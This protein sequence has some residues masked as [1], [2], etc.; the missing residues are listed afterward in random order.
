MVMKT[1]TLFLFGAV[2]ATAVCALQLPAATAEQNVPVTSVARL[3]VKEVTVFKDGHA[4]VA[5]EGKLPVNAAGEVVMDYL[6]TPVIGTFWAYPA[7]RNAKLVSVTASQRRMSIERTAL[8]LRELLEANVGAEASLTETN[9]LKYPVTI[10]GFPTRSAEE[11]MATSPPNAGERLPQKGSLVLLKTA[12]GT[13]ALPVDRIQDVTF[14]GA[15]AAKSAQE[16]FRN[17]LTLRMD[18]GNRK[19]AKDAEVG[20]GLVYL[21]KGIRWIPSYR[22]DLD[23]KG[24]AHIRLQATLLNELTDLDDVTVQL[25]IGV[26]TFYFKET[27]DPMALQESAAQ[28]SAFFQGEPGRAGRSSVLAANFSNAIMTQAARMGDYRAESGPAGGSGPDLPEGT[29]NEDLFVFTLKNISL[30]KG[31]RMVVP[32]AEYEVTYEDVFVLDLPF[33]PPPEMARNMNTQQHAELAK[34]FNAPK[35]MHKARLNNKSAQPFTTAPAL[36]LREGRVISQGLMTYTAI[37]ASTDLALTTA[38]DIQVKKTDSETKRTPNAFQHNGDQYMRVDLKGTIRLTNRRGQPLAVEVTRHVL[39][40]VD[41]AERDGKV[42]MSNA[43]ESRDHLPVGDYESGPYYWWNWISWP[44]W[45]HQ[46]NGVGRVTWELKLD[47]GQ[48]TELGYTWH[49]YWR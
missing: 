25:V 46:V 6:P 24:K 33:A 30:K 17:F 5:H 26:P 43:F 13:K 9:G 37:G 48:Q 12:E 18:W 8:T 40:H 3:P 11:L 41:A 38:V 16:E 10:L 23:G 47:Q 44:W 49:Y 27:L 45:W 4:F 15:P 21:Q 20:V 22:V 35:V 7:D 14:K 31:A 1:K 29:K 2:V 36:V 32:V 34:L 19:P 39:G 42:E 28:L